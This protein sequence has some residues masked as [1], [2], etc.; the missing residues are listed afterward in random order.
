MSGI[1]SLLFAEIGYDFVACTLM[2][3]SFLW[4]E[5]WLSYVFCSHY[6]MYDMQC[7]RLPDCV[8]LIGIV[9]HKV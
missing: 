5:Y 1:L 4:S 6:L 7:G 2:S 8:M 9:G 3:K